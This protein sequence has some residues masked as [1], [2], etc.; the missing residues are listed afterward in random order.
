VIAYFVALYS[1]AAFATSGLGL[2]QAKGASLQSILSAAQM[3]GRPCW[4]LAL[5]KGGRINMTA[6]CYLVVGISCLA[7][8][9]PATSYGVLVLFAIVQGATSGTIWN[10]AA[11]ITAQMVGVKHLASALS[12]FWVTLAIPALVGQP[13]A[14]LLLEFSENHQGRTGASA[15]YNT[16]GFSGAMG[17]TGSLML[18]GA[19]RYQQGNWKIL[20][21]S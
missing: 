16:I 6:I 5:D 4:G 9:L 3:I 17:I 10:A 11:P 2:S 7:I 12:I 13:L 18:I 1:L 19:K 21:K 15:Y 20:T 14:I 8:W